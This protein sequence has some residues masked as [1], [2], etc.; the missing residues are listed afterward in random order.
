M[1]QMIKVVALLAMWALAALPAQAQTRHALVIGI[2][3]YTDVTPLQKARNDARA[4]GQALEDAGVQVDLVLDA[5]E[6]ELLTRVSAFSGRL[7]AGDEAIIFF[8]GHGVEV[9]GRNYLLP[10]DIPA[11]EPRQEFIMMRRSLPLDD[12]LDM[13]H[14]RDVRLSLVVLDACRNN[15]FPR[16]GTRSLGG[17][18]GL[19][20]VDPPEGTFIL[21]SAGAGQEALDRMSETDPE[22]NSVFT[23]AL[24]P[25]LGTPGLGLRDV[26][27]QVR[28]DVRQSALSIG[29]DQF[30][31]VYDQLD[32][33]FTLI[34]AVQRAP[35]PLDPCDAARADWAMIDDSTSEDLLNA[36]LSAHS[37]CPLL[38]AIAQD[39]LAALTPAPAP[40]PEP[41]AVED[42]CDAARLVWRLIDDSSD[43]DVL[44][45]YAESFATSC[46]ALSQQAAERAE[47]AAQAVLALRPAQ[48][49]E[50]SACAGAAVSLAPR[51]NFGSVA[52][53]LEEFLNSYPNCGAHSKFA[54]TELS[55]R[56][57][58]RAI[59]AG[60]L[61][62]E[63]R[64]AL[65]QSQRVD[66]QTML[67]DIGFQ[68]GTPDGAF[69]P[70]SRAAIKG[71][72]RNVLKVESEHLS[73]E[74]LLLLKQV[75]SLA[76]DGVDGRWLMTFLRRDSD[77]LRR[78]ALD[79]SQDQLLES[80]VLRIRDGVA[81]VESTHIGRPV[82]PAVLHSI[83]VDAN[84]QL[85]VEYTGH[86]LTPERPEARRLR[87]SLP[88]GK[89]PLLNATSYHVVGQYD[90]SFTAIIRLTRQ[91]YD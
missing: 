42:P 19:G 80:Y 27:Q 85:Q 83:R 20:R 17:T 50:S 15:P 64:L 1:V 87:G 51:L 78:N 66:I 46:P 11:V 28:R 45:R 22:P 10:A 44:N 69:G 52:S 3:S 8:A 88:L 37:E 89:R 63:N 86:Y 13:L 62:S 34:P 5:G 59:V 23:R 56:Q 60:T 65:D 18:R 36:F 67:N 77:D 49:V 43:P 72:N 79:H 16:R 40:A 4:V 6:V 26:V 81:V 30:P 53:S 29:H 38:V 58:G 71:F 61:A 35:Q 90:D 47:Q 84:G 82:R 68:S 74:N 54:E 9:D 21:F 2:D 91:S 55:R 73:A 14:R 32:G 33:D 31:A 41:V 39:R 24:L 12:L 7:R 70:R 25:L 76:P 75:H 48:P 57:A